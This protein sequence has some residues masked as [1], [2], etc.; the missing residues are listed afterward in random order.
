MHITKSKI[1]T[2]PPGERTQR[3]WDERLKGFGVA[4]SPSGVKS[5]VVRYRVGRGRRAQ[6]RLETIGRYGALT[7]DEARTKAREILS[8]AALGQDHLAH[9]RER[10]AELSIGELIEMWAVQGAPVHRRTGRMRKQRSVE[11]DIRQMR[12]HVMPRLGRKRLSELRKADIEALRLAIRQGDIRYERKTKAR[13]VQRIRG[14]AGAAN[15][16]VAIFKSALAWAEDQ[17][18]IEWSPGRKVRVP[19]AKRM[20]DYQPLNRQQFAALG[21]ALKTLSSDY[22]EA[23]EIILLLAL[24]GARKS[25]IERLKWA[26]IMPDGRTLRLADAKTERRLLFLGPIA[27]G[28]LARRTPQAGSIYV[29]P[30]RRGPNHYQDM[31]KIWKRA[32]EL[33]GLPSTLKRKDLRHSYITYGSDNRIAPVHMQAL[34][35]HANLS[36]T[37]LYYHGQSVEVRRAAAE[38]EDLITPMM[39][40]AIAAVSTH[41]DCLRASK[42][43]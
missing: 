5:F 14:G 2:L 6:Q 33:A 13:G 7:A 38:M 15:R 12:T 25:E 37:E 16:T 31:P 22:P 34:V 39:A 8:R 42:S 20:Q 26:E 23:V 28:L 1:D 4:V 17:E 43:D 19:Q 36:T 30:A 21:G 9:Q 3:Y 41:K 40:G 11:H 24:T 35:G 10:A 29:F 32:L 27:A 18:L